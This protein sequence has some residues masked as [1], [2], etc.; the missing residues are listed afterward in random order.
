ML[1][2]NNIFI[3]A[4]VDMRTVSGCE[5]NIIA[6]NNDGNENN[7]RNIRQLCGEHFFL[8]NQP[9]HAMEW[10]PFFQTSFIILSSPYFR[11]VHF[12]SFDNP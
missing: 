3:L 7:K 4:F 12:V 11:K 5:Q 1:I 6:R 9:P 2:N 8:T 10:R